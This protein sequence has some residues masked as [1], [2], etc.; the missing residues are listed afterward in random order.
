VSA[1]RFERRGLDVEILGRAAPDLVGG[2]ARGGVGEGV[3][4]RN[5]A[6]VMG[7]CL[8]EKIFSIEVRTSG[9]TRNKCSQTEITQGWCEGWSRTAN[10]SYQ[11]RGGWWGGTHVG[12][13]VRSSG[14]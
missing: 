7:R 2:G 4:V 9:V 10:Q 11:S 5:D 6:D 3:F 13:R 1:A 12:A 14:L 8:R